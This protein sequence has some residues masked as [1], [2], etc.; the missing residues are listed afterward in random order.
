MPALYYTFSKPIPFSTQTVQFVMLDTSALTGGD[1][2][3]WDS[4]P[5]N[6]PQPAVDETQWAWVESTL[7]AA[8][9]DWLIVVGHFPVYSAGENGPTPALVA[10]L[11][12]L[13]EA[14]GVALYICG[15]DHQL[16]HIAP[17]PGNAVDF[18]VVGSAA[19]YNSSEA[20]LADIPTGSLKFQWGASCGF[21]SVSISRRGYLPAE[22]TAS[23]WNGAGDLLYSFTKPN[24]RIPDL[25]PAPPRPG[26]PPSVFDTQS[27]RRAVMLGSFALLSGL[28]LICST[29]G[30]GGGRER[31]G[32]Q[33]P[34]LSGGVAGERA[35]LLMQRPV[36]FGAVRGGGSS[37]RSVT[38]RL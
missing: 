30:R 28:F 31:G 36:A 3:Q 33:A 22:L 23:L 6:I 11:L 21:A 34:G 37:A 26:A 27:N 18:L 5:P 16:E 35:A 7:A 19:K 15:H 4:A 25:P 1:A 9:A 2:G 32:Q 8:T 29:V 14:A 17:A 12:P 38:N 13:M 20:H 10:R 24:P